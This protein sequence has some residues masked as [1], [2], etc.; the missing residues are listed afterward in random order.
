MEQIMHA[1]LPAH[2]KCGLV[3]ANFM[4]KLVLPLRSTQHA[5]SN[6]GTPMLSTWS[7]RSGSAGRT[8]ATADEALTGRLL[9]RKKNT[10]ASK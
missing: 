10:T 9:E 7:D 8:T 3:V 6:P 2:K 4:A 1:D 5:I